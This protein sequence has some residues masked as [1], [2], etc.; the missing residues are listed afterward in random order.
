MLLA[1][2]ENLEDGMLAEVNQVGAR[3]YTVLLLDLD[4][5]QYVDGIVILDSF[6]EATAYAQRLIR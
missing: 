4:S 6:E 1:E 5:D 2:Y 3:H